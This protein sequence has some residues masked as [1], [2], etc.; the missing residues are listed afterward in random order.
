MEKEISRFAK[1]INFPICQFLD[2]LAQ[3]PFD[4]TK[5]TLSFL[6]GDPTVYGQKQF[7]MPARGTTVFR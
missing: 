1:G 4:H 5:K 7:Q 6:S 2:Q 3:E